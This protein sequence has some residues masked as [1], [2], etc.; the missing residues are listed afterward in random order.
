MAVT[1]RGV[2]HKYKSSGVSMQFKY[3]E[4]QKRC[5]FC[6]IFMECNETRCPCCHTK[7]RTKARNK[8]SKENYK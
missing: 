1:C 2:C 5:S 6:G 8:I 4:G 3:Q 7:L